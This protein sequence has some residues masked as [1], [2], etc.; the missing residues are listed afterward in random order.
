MEVLFF[1]PIYRR[2]LLTQLLV[3]FSFV[4]IIVAFA[5]LMLFFVQ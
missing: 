3:T 5:I 4:L 1:R 2:P